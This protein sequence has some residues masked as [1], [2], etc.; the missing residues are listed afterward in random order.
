MGGMFTVMKI[1][2]DLPPNDYKDPGPYK[3]PQGTVAYEFKGEAAQ[4]PAQR[5]APTPRKPE[6]P[7]K[8]PDMSGT[9]HP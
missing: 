1:R 9:K 2:E 7:M 3:H 6:A 4:T 5:S 8:M